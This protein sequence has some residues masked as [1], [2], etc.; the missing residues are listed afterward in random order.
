[1]TWIT[2]AL[3]QQKRD[4][5]QTASRMNNI[6]TLKEKINQQM[7]SAWDQ[8]ADAIEGDARQFNAAG[9]HWVVERPQT[10]MIRVHAENEIAALFTLEIEPTRGTLHYVCPVLAGRPGVPVIGKFQ[11][12]AG[13]NEAHVMGEKYPNSRGPVVEFTPEQVSQLLFSATLF[14]KNA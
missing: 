1:M 4:A 3:D 8:I 5:E 7:P 2:E 11:I 10:T 6:L 9:G 13:S 14:P 12:R